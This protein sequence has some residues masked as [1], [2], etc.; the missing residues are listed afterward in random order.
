[1]RGLLLFSDVG[2]LFSGAG[3]VGWML[4]NVEGVESESDAVTLGQLLLDRGAIF[5]SEGSM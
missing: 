3:I 4:E 5:H 2:A 1:M